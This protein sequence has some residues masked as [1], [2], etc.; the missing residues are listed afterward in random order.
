MIR[1]TTLLLII[2]CFLGGCAQK[3]GNYVFE[4][5]DSVKIDESKVVL[6][7]FPSALKLINDSVAAAINSAQK[8]SL[9]NINDGK[10]FANFSSEKINF[11][12]LI[13]Q[14]F[15][16][17]YAGKRTY[18]YDRSSAAGL[19]DGNCQM[20]SF[21]FSDGLFYLY[22]NTLVQ[23]EYVN[24]SAELRK[25]FE[26]EKVKEMRKENADATVQIMQYLEFIFVIDPQLK[27]KEIIPLYERS[28]LKEKKY[29]A[30][31]QKG[32]AINAGKLFVPI[33]K[34]DQTFD[35]I[36]SPLKWSTGLYTLT[37]LD[38]KD[39]E[40]TDYKLS[41]NDISFKE[42]S[43]HNYFGAS[44]IFKHSSDGL[45]F[46]NGKEICNVETALKIFEKQHLKANEWI[47]NFHYLS[48]KKMVLI[49]YTLDKKVKPTELEINYG[50]DSLSGVKIKIF[51]TEKS[52]WSV[53]K[54][55]PA[56]TTLTYVTTDKKIIS[57]GK[58]KEH[59]Y[60]KSIRFNEN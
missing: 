59:Y 17:K 19:S 24:D 32:I 31:Y 11:D 43:L 54:V 4:N 30:Y 29:T 39:N 27:L 50:V 57:F 55:L 3:A 28:D 51:D 16:K 6:T 38:L 40:K 8:L 46:S 37:T 35:K 47:Q 48:N 5:A 33:L 49:T 14:T 23:V 58:D 7:K 21:D 13:K 52:G 26:K 53:E 36:T 34:D 41:Y 60:F 1:I 10:N 42:Y 44:F 2:T 22:V 9:Y 56:N 45:L 12:S 15:S 25:F 20:L 18:I